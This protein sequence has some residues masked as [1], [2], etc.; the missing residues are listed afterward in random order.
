MTEKSY[1]W[2]HD[3]NFC[4]VLDIHYKKG[5]QKPNPFIQ[6]RSPVSI[7]HSQAKS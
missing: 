3:P 4:I 1:V 7:A 5:F 2:E 6:Q